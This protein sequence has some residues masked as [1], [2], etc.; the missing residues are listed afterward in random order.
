MGT[1]KE[2]GCIIAISGID[3]SGKSTCADMIKKILEKQ[4]LESVILDSMKGGPIVTELMSLCECYHSSPRK[5]ISPMLFNLAW[6][7][8][9]IY[10]YEKNVKSII[11]SGKSVI[12]HRSELCCRVY[13]KLFD[14]KND[15]IDIILNR[16]QITYDMHFFLDIN[17]QKAY[18]RIM[19]RSPDELTD[20]ECLEKLM[21]ADE[22]YRNYLKTTSYINTNIIKSDIPK[23]QLENTLR[24]TIKFFLFS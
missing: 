11:E 19:G 18:K 22:I 17:P 6:T 16:Q 4:G 8:D 13:S 24:D 10:N 20:K 2:M 12:L 14:T 3:G 1:V 15:L 7:T 23:D 21:E 5:M 9:L